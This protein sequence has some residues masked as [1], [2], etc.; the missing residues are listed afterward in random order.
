MPTLL[1][2]VRRAVIRVFNMKLYSLADSAQEALETFSVFT[3]EKPDLVPLGIRA[4]DEAIG[5]MYPGTGV[6]IA[7][8]TGIGKSSIALHGALRAAEEGVPVGIVSIE[9]GPDVIGVRLLSWKSGVPTLDIRRGTLD[10][11][12][13]QRLD[14]ARVALEAMEYPVMAYPVGRPIEDV[15]DVLRAMGEAGIRLVYIDYLQKIRGGNQ[16]RRN[17]VAGNFTRMQ[18]ICYDRGM[19]PVIISQLSRGFDPD[20]PPSIHMLKESGDLENEA[21][22]IILLW[23][24]TKEPDKLQL[25][26]GKSTFGGERVRAE[27]V[28]NKAGFL[29]EV[30]EEFGE[31]F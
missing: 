29:V 7:A 20:R 6:I 28:R 15:E 11:D 22:L 30:K 18:R 12:Q 24:D 4:V 10:P 3:G 25:K 17:E 8:A 26:V 31:E 9:D 23:R 27:Y 2:D 13:L 16:D 5:G 14:K 1:V 21:R 19:V